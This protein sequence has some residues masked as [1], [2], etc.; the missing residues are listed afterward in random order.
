[1]GTPIARCASLAHDHRDTSRPF[2][3]VASRHAFGNGPKY[4]ATHTAVPLAMKG[5]HL[6]AKLD[7]VNPIGSKRCGVKVQ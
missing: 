1:M 7:Y 5:M 4:P 2:P 3:G 6:F